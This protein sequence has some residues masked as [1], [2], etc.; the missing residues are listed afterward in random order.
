M[1]IVFVL[2]CIAFAK[3][4]VLEKVMKMENPMNSQRR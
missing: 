2:L 1:L 3:S 4:Y